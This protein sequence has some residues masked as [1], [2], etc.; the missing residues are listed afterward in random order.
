MT[1]TERQLVSF[2]N[3]LLTRYGVMVYSN[4]GKNQPIYQREVHDA[5]LCNWKDENPEFNHSLFPSR[6][7]IGDMVKVF[8]MP[9][10]EKEFP[11]FTGKIT[12]VHFTNSKV[13]YDV[14]LIFAGDFVS[15]IYNVDSVLVQPLPKIN[16]EENLEIED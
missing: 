16:M 10:G 15:R 7:A 11:G 4:D 6:H 2:G 12:A 1:Y 14:E 8:L 9:E 13:K 3:Y 5:D